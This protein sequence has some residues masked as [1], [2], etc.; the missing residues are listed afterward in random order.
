MRRWPVILT[1]KLFGN[2]HF[3]L[4]DFFAEQ[5][6]VFAAKTIRLHD[7]SVKESR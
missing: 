5:M 4:L 1:M 7:I 6:M 2:Q 3:L